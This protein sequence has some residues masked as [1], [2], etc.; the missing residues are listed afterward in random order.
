RDT[1]IDIFYE[2]HLGQLIKV[3]TASCSPENVATANNKSI[4]PDQGDQN[5]S[6]TKPEIL[7]NICELL[8]FCVLHH[9]YRIKYILVALQNSELTLCC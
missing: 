2:K 5:H 6:G 9:P 1:I 7:L 8:C 3:I 4:D